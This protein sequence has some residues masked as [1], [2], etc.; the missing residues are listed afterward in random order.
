MVLIQDVLLNLNE[1]PIFV[2]GGILRGEVFSSMLMMG[3]VGCQMGT[4]FACAKESTAHRDFKNAFFRASGR[5]AVTTIQLDKRF[6]ISLVRALENNATDEFMKKQKE[7]IEKF[8]NREIQIEE[9]RLILEKFYAGSLRRAVQEGD[10]ECGSL[11][12][13]Q[14][15]QAINEERSIEEIIN[16]I[17]SE[18]EN[19]LSKLEKYV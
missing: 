8:E 11:M 6:P 13:G 19:Y 17:L 5:N 15:V 1:Y 12:A 16:T 10:I 14:I 18:S 3:A 7:V 2:A 9:G 4:V